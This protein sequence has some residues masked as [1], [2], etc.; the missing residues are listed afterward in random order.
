[1]YP[2]SKEQQSFVR[3]VLTNA[4]MSAYQ[5]RRSGK[6]ASGDNLTRKD[7]G[8]LERYIGELRHILLSFDLSTIQLDEIAKRF[9]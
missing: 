5:T 4:L 2:L 7:R 1:M 3:T 9:G 8:E 6:G